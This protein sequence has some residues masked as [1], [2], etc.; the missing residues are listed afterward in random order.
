MAN[1]EYMR[2]LD[3]QIKASMAAASASAAAGEDPD[4]RP[5]PKGGRGGGGGSRRDRDTF[6]GFDADDMGQGPRGFGGGEWSE[7]YGDARPP[8]RKSARAP[9]PPPRASMVEVDPGAEDEGSMAMEDNGAGFDGTMTDSK[10][11]ARARIEPDWAPC[12]EHE[13]AIKNPNIGEVRQPIEE[14]FG[15]MYGRGDCPALPYQKW[16]ELEKMIRSRYH[17]A[18]RLVMA[19]AIHL[20]HEKNLRAPTLPPK[21]LPPG[22]KP[23]PQWLPATI[24]D[25]F[26]NHDPDFTARVAKR[27]RQV[28]DMI[29]CCR[30]DQMYVWAKDKNGRQI[31]DIT[32]KPLRRLH[33]ESVKEL[34]TLV[35]LEM[36][37]YSMN[38]RTAMFSSDVGTSVDEIRPLLSTAGKA[39]STKNAS[40]FTGNS[41]AG[42][43]MGAGQGGTV[44]GQGGRR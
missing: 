19:Q 16:V 22:V 34:A 44:G 23:L 39:F 36:K 33:T 25:H 20:F 10:Q 30:R 4:L 17:H 37:L 32:G 26:E 2:K 14:C 7:A 8:P 5:L 18:D 9:P 41:A 28:N 6:E 43:S 12:I 3:E 13:T 15:C 24:L 1:D 40:I 38:P 11:W 35:A 29:E 31:R 21:K 27:I 42:Q